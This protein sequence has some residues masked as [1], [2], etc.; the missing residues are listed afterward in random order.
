MFLHAKNTH[1]VTRL[2]KVIRKLSARQT[3]AFFTPVPSHAIPPLAAAV[4]FEIL[5]RIVWADPEGPTAAMWSYMFNQSC[6]LDMFFTVIQDFS[7]GFAVSGGLS[8][9]STCSVCTLEFH[10]VPAVLSCGHS[11]C[12][13]CAKKVERCPF[14]RVPTEGEPKPNYIVTSFVESRHARQFAV[15]REL[16]LAHLVENSWK[17]DHLVESA[18]LRHF[19]TAENVQKVT[20]NCLKHLLTFGF[21]HARTFSAIL[22]HGRI[23]GW[24]LNVIDLLRVIA[25]FD[26]SVTKESAERV[27]LEM[28]KTFGADVGTIVQKLVAPIL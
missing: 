8:D 19:L 15:H 10:P 4:A 5:T 20:A 28:G 23:S 2:M 6:V 24:E 9:L 14:C 22:Q 11:L 1:S 26:R 16:S 21:R 27:I 3:H 13:E 18:A 7:E 12:F 17:L 25:E